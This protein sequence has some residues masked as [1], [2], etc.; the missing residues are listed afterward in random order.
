MGFSIKIN[1]ECHITMDKL[2]FINHE[3]IKNLPTYPDW[4]FNQPSPE[5]TGQMMAPVGRVSRN[6]SISFNKRPLQSD[7][8]RNHGPVDFVPL[9]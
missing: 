4:K 7:D 1:V 8:F 6:I 3:G 2:V 5:G 9:K